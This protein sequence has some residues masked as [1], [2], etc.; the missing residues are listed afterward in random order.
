M[1]V[2]GTFYT[3]V[4]DTCGERMELNDE[5]GY[6]VVETLQEAESTLTDCEWQKGEGGELTCSVC[7]EEAFKARMAAT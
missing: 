4:C 5:G 2:E 7:A 6:L 1:I 3:L